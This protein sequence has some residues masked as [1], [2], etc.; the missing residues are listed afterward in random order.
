MLGKLKFWKKDD[1]FDFD[2]DALGQEPSF[3]PHSG[4]PQDQSV[5]RQDFNPSEPLASP[6]PQASS[7]NQQ[8]SFQ[9]SPQNSNRELELVVAKLDALRVTLESMNQRLANLERI[10]QQS[11]DSYT[12][13]RK[14][15][16]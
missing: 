6:I 14:K 7:F 5:P 2:N 12:E 16:W 15:T 11:D 4:N 9:Q 1:D 10:A 3:Q 13:Y 8:Q